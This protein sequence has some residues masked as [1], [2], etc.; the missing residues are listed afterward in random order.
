[1]AAELDHDGRSEHWLFHGTKPELIDIIIDQ[2]MDNRVGSGLLG[3][4]TY[5]AESASKSDQYA[6]KG[7]KQFMFLAR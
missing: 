3:T 6:P 2:G 5:F 7:P 1:M 4:G